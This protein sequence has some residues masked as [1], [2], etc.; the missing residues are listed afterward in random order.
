MSQFRSKE[1]KK[2]ESEWYAIVSESG[3]VDIE[4]TVNEERP[5]KDWHGS[6]LGRDAT[7]RGPEAIK[8]TMTYYSCA[9]ELL[10]VYQFQDPLHRKI[11]ELHCEGMPVREIAKRVKKIKYVMVHYVIARIRKEIIT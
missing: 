4:D 7:R 11:W 8:A 1:F 5:L 10:H 6:S 3:F 2:L 9:A